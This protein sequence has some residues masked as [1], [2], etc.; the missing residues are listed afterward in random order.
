MTNSLRLC[1]PATMPLFA[2]ISAAPLSLPDPHRHRHRHRHRRGGRET[3]SA[4]D[5]PLV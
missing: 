3:R 2:A 4:R 1:E 5:G